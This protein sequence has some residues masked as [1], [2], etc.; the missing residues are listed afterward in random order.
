ERELFGHPIPEVK[1]PTDIHIVRGE[2]R[3][4]QLT[5]AAFPTAWTRQA[6]ERLNDGKI[7]VLVLKNQEIAYSSWL[8]FTSEVETGLRYRITVGSNEAY[9]FNSFTTP[10]FRG[11]G[12]HNLMTIYQLQLAKGMGKSRILGIVHSDNWAA[13]HVW[14]KLHFQTRAVIRRISIGQKDF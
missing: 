11:Q 10:E 9:I 12:L 4:L 5:H 1:Q 3:H 6:K 14:E 2:E 7:W 8:S 13:R